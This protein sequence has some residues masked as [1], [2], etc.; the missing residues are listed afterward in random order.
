MSEP[1]VSSSTAHDEAPGASPGAN[2][3]R[4]PEQ[5]RLLL[6]ILRSR[7]GTDF[8]QY[9]VS[10]LQR[11]LD[12]RMF[13]TGHHTLASYLEMLRKSPEEQDALSAAFLIKVS[14]FFRDPDAWRKVREHVVP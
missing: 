4:S 2:G 7:S 13:Q 1:K 11:R 6:A 8:S 10:T 5:W 9:K 3:G 12:K 14:S